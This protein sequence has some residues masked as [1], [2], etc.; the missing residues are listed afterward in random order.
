MHSWQ[1]MM[2]ASL[3]AITLSIAL[4]GIAAAESARPDAPTNAADV[5][6][7][8]TLA[9]V[10]R[11]HPQA[12]CHIEPSRDFSREGGTETRYD[13]ER[14]LLTTVTPARF[15]ATCTLSFDDGPSGR[16]DLMLIL[17]GQPPTFHAAYITYQDTDYLTVRK[18]FVGLYGEPHQKVAP[19]QSLFRRMKRWI[20]R[21]VSE[22]EK[23]TWNRKHATVTLYHPEYEELDRTVAKVFVVIKAV[24]R[25]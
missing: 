14:G 22:V 5:V 18:L 17:D 15:S 20:G 19:R 9:E 1:T 13:I 2:R 3:L 8:A 11:V 12:S 23:L 6:W 16:G 24:N 10:Q 4:T 21:P 7:G 25:P